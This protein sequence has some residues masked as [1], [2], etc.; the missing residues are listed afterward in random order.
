MKILY[1]M[2][3]KNVY[4]LEISKKNSTPIGTLWINFKILK[5]IKQKGHLNLYEQNFTN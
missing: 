1:D 4:I 3:I 5:G 2:L